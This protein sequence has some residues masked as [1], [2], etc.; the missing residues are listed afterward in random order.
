M[1]KV[2]VLGDDTRSFLTTVRSLGRQRI[3]VHAAPIDF[4]SPALRSRYV[5]ATHRLP[6]WVGNGSAWLDA[7][8][9]LIRAS[10]FDMVIPC[11]ETG[12]LPLARYRDRFESLTRLAIPHDRAIEV[13]FDKQATREL[14]AS[15]GIPVA[16]GRLLRPDDTAPGIFAE[17]GGPV[18]FKPRRSYTLETLD[19][20]GR[21]RILRSQD[22]I[23]ANL[24]VPSPDDYLLEGFF[25]GYGAGV[26]VLA[27]RGRVVQAFQHRR[28]RESRSG[29]S[30]YR[31]SVAL[32]PDLLQA[33]ESI[34]RAVDYTGLAMFEF[35]CND[36]NDT[37]LLL[38]VNARPWG[39]LPLPVALGIDFPFR[40][41]RLLADGVTTPGVDYPAAVYGRN[42]LPDL[43]ELTEAV[44][45]AGRNGPRVALCRLAEF[46]RC[47]AGR[48]QFDT[49]VLDDL[50]PGL[51]EIGAV[52][53]SVPA[54]AMRR[55]PG[56]NRAYGFLAR[57]R[58]R[59]AL[60]RKA[61]G[62]LRLLFVCAGNICR[63]PYAEAAL[64]TIHPDLAD[65]LEISSAGTLPRAGGRPTPPAGVFAARTR[66]IDLSRH[67]SSHFSD[68]MAF[69]ADLIVVF[70]QQNNDA[71]SHRHP[72]L[73]NRII[74]LGDISGPGTIADP[75]DGDEAEFELCYGR[76]ERGLA[77]MAEVLRASSSIP[78]F[79]A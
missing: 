39:S 48:E 8:E 21:V 78:S 20:R 43:A 22:E 60:R 27:D 15:L 41:Y 66:G 71:V 1:H 69:A 76:I 24:P 55:I 46:W 7:L 45:D 33:C 32:R 63:S 2:L 13:L 19:R 35:R 18:M 5:T 10:R 57:R 16:R 65:R 31:V 29:G 75:V 79:S 54:R 11:S 17:F 62:K 53:I 67:R 26:S 51:A 38:E 28:I 30:Y 59:A 49:L 61:R 37:W 14:A 58:L 64:A 74:M 52:L 6:L 70:D 44:E 36:S 4:A 72:D 47:F 23:A 25:P 40:W 56:G 34:T 73:R 77:G 12:L 50:R 9:H 3:D 68:E 42:L